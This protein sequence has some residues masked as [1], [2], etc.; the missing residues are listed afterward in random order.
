MYI[1]VKTQEEGIMS[2]F[3]KF[4]DLVVCNSTFFIKV[5][6]CVDGVSCYI[7]Q[8]R[9]GVWERMSSGKG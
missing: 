7:C 5:M 2:F 3:S 1:D 6:A 4:L 8:K 9:N